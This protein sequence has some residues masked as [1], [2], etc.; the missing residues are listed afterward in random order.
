MR[1][2]VFFAPEASSASRRGA[3]SKGSAETR[4]STSAARHRWNEGHFR[5]FGH[6]RVPRAEGTV[7][8]DLSTPDPYSRLYLWNQPSAGTVWFDDI[9]VADAPIG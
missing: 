4:N 3:I 6:V 5:A 7:D 8:G 9:K 1:T 2:L